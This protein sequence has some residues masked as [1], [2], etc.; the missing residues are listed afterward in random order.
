MELEFIY[1]TVLNL[2]ALL[3]NLDLRIAADICW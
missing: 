2:F 3:N 1:V